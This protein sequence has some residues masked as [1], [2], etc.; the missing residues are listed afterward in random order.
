MGALAAPPAP[1]RS[2]EPVNRAS[3]GARTLEQRL[4]RALARVR[5]NGEADCPV[6]GELLH[7]LA[8]GAECGGCGSRLD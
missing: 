3:G 1:A 4:D 6:C 7:R 5:A 8:G 2:S